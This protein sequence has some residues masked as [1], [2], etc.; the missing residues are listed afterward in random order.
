MSAGGAHKGAGAEKPDLHA[1]PQIKE[2]ISFLY[3]ERCVLNRQDNAITVT[4]ARGTVHVPSAALGAI[5]LGPGTKITHRAMELVGDMG[6][7]VIWVGESGVRYYA[8]GRPLT[9]SSHML[10]AQASLVSNART[11]V[12]VA[13][14]MYSMRFPGEDVSSMSMQQLR[15]REGARIRSVYRAMSHK[16]GVPWNGREYDPE[17][18]D[19]GDIV[20]KALSAAHACLY[21]MAHSVIAALGCSPGLG[22]IHTGH[23]LSFV[24]DI[25]DLYKAETTIPIAFEVAAKHTKQDDIGAVTRRA[26]RD[27]VSGGQLLAQIARD[28]RYLL[29]GGD[30][31]ADADAVADV[32]INVLHLWDDKEG[33]V[34]NAV[35]YGREAGAGIEGPVEDDSELEVGY[36]T[37]AEDKP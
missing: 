36:G 29:L 21:G 5:L 35:N 34:R 18:F 31:D 10:V 15:G 22:F 17:N 7:S 1:L 32:E 16:T 13:R 8:H 19:S 6:A 11:R 27:S 24:Y 20:N 9:H 28:L 33:F 2:R 4:D 14:R 30:A 23:E 25:A 37:I 3:L 26:V 12:A